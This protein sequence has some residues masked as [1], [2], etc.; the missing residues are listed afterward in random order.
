[1]LYICLI[2]KGEK[3]KRI[4]VDAGYNLNSIANKLGISPQN[5]QKWLSVQ[6][7]KTGILE[8][9]ATAI[10]KDI[11][12]FFEKEGTTNI[13]DGNVLIAANAKK[14][15]VGEQYINY[16]KDTAKELREEIK[17]L[18]KEKE[19]QQKEIE[20]LTRQLEL[21]ERHIQRLEKLIDK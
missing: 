16:G 18:K 19:S 21:Q 13:Y 1:M 6:D 4:L 11:F 12:F 15:V 3:V 9:I 7:M 5:F 17:F 2:M 14:T 8:K 20:S 10:D